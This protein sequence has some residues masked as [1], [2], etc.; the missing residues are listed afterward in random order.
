MP[1]QD[2]FNEF[3]SDI[4]FQEF[5]ATAGIANVTNRSFDG[6][7]RRGGDTVHVNFI[8][9]SDLTETTSVGTT[10]DSNP[11]ISKA[12]LVDD[13]ISF[14]V[15]LP[16]VDQLKTNMNFQQELALSMAQ[17]MAAK[18]DQKLIATVSGSGVPSVVINSYDSLVDA[19]SVLAGNGVNVNPQD[20]WYFPSTGQ[21]KALKKD[22]D[23]QNARNFFDPSNSL[24]TGQI[25]I[26][27]GV[28]VVDQ[29]VVPGQ[30]IMFHKSA[31]AFVTRE[32]VQFELDS[33]LGGTNQ[34]GAVLASF[35]LCGAKVLSDKAVLLVTDV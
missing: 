16:A 31:L 15:K 29:N 12:I 9:P 10:A 25:G 22:P 34:R 26:V 28:N 19:A 27:N 18:V 13:D 23:I 21:S 4:A 33:T 2:T 35:M 24:V 1:L 8:D 32:D 20:V 5:L 3:W 30:G 7:I 14:K 6:D 17:R 11:A